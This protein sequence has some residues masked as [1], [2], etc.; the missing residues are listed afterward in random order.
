MIDL[1]EHQKEGMEFLKSRTAGGLFYEMGLG[2]T[3]TTLATLEE[4][5]VWPVLVVCPL[6]VVGVWAAEVKK[7]GFKRKVLSLVGSRFERLDLLEEP[8]DIYVINYD[9]MRILAD[10]LLKRKWGAIVLDE[11]H[12]IKNITS[13]QTKVALKL[14]KCAEHRYILTGTPITKTPED[15]W[16]Q[17]YFLDPTHF[18]N[19]YAFRAR[20]VEYKVRQVRT[21]GGM[22]E[23]RIPYRF[24][25]LEELEEK[26]G[27]I[28]LRKTKAECLDLPEKIYKKIYCE[29]EG[30]QKTHYYELK[31]SLVAML[32]SGNFE[33]RAGGA[34][35]QK[36]R[37]VCQGFLYVNED[38]HLTKENVKL[39]YL[40]DLLEDI[41]GEKKILYTYFKAETELLL[42]ELSKTQKVFYYDGSPDERALTIAG[43]EEH[44]G[45]AILLMQIDQAIG[46]NLAFVSHVIYY[47][48]SWNYATR[49]Q[50]EDRAHRIGQKNSVVYYDFVCPRTID[51]HV[52]DLLLIKKDLAD[53]VTGDVKKLAQNYLNKY[54][55]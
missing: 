22:R 54:N 3:L 20:H 27:R 9:G 15:V 55:S 46:M 30:D 23:V 44:E 16:S 10:E 49:L 8:A 13:T 42:K 51:E 28:C 41:Q 21:P 31:H 18:T 47:S 26:M 52:L 40:K 43:F 39:K 34:L 37:Q 29:L 38:T 19:F 7:F 25:N 12:R 48:N 24:K 6:S 11:S 4:K 33:V 53:Q 50:S 35:V 32:E 1:K 14:S 45:D 5:N 36:L 2:K 17:I